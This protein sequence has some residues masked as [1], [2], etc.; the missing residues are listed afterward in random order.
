M[1]KSG[2]DGEQNGA[3]GHFPRGVA[4]NTHSGF[5]FTSLIFLF[6]P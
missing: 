6:L 5:Y 4:L 2:M 3:W 1:P